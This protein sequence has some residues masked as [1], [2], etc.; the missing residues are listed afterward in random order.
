[1][2]E[3][4]YDW[5]PQIYVMC[6]RDYEKERFA[7]LQNHLLSRGIPDEKLHWVSSLWGSELSSED[8]FKIYDPFLRSSSWPYSLSYKS[9]ALSRGEVSLHYAFI[10]TLQEIVSSSSPFA[11]IFESDVVLREDFMDRLKNLM[12]L[13]K[14]E[15]WDYISLGE[16]VG[17]RPP[18]SPLSY[19]KETKLYK[20]VGPWVFR[21]TDSMLLKKDFLDKISKTLIPVRECLDWELNY[22]IIIHNGDSLWADPPLVEPSSGRNVTMSHLLG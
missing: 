16:G 8:Y 14:D 21:C 5:M 6:N 17:T 12:E 2:N 4:T 22:Q 11:I 19:F 3:E 20:A 13:Q 10:S 18:G 9:S 1:M 15:K 7:F